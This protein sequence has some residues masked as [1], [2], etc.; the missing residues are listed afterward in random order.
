MSGAGKGKRRFVFA[1]DPGSTTGIALLEPV[2]GIW[3]AGQVV[4]KDA[5]LK[6]EKT[7]EGIQHTGAEM[8]LDENAGVKECLAWATAGIKDIYLEMLNTDEAFNRAVEGAEAGRRSTAI[9]KVL[10]GVD[11]VDSVPW[12][13][14]SQGELGRG[15]LVVIEDFLIRLGGRGASS[16]RSGISP[17]RISAGLVAWLEVMEWDVDHG[18]H[19]KLQQASNAK[20]VITDPRLKQLGMWIPGKEHARDALRH[21]VL[22]V[23]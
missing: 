7:L 15:D 19:L 12:E 1:V 22:S 11:G 10:G 14:W 18:V 6:A 5:H 23:R 8:Y 2:S 3:R 13:A 20:G 4:C 21:A 9:S 17:A 16:A